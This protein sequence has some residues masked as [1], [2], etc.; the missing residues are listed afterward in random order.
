MIFFQNIFGKIKANFLSTFQSREE[1]W[2]RDG[3][4][5]GLDFRLEMPLQDSQKVTGVKLLLFFDY[6]L[7]VSIYLQLTTNKNVNR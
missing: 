3:K 6:K 2:N 5:D 1:D 4:A 7:Y